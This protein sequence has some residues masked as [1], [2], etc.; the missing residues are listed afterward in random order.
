MKPILIGV[1]SLVVLVLLVAIVGWMQPVAH[2]AARQAT[3]QVP[4]D[5]LYALLTDI[6]AFPSWR[7]GLRSAEL[8]TPE[9]TV[10]RQFRETGKNGAIL[11]AFE[12][13]TPPR[14][15]VTRIVDP[16]L[17]FGGSWTFELTPEGKGTTLRITE[18]GEVYN[19]IFRFVSRFFMS[20]TATVE[21]YLRDVGKH[22]GEDVQ[23]PG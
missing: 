7:S 1:A 15:I 2:R 3:Y 10:P 16:K 22:Y 8:V 14:R 21:T 4:A 18:D 13:L 9:G 11:F 6:P 17:P 5:S 12:E 19:P 20:P 23:A